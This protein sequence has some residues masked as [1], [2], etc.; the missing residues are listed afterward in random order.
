MLQIVK[1]ITLRAFF[2]IKGTL[3][4]DSSLCTRQ[5]IFQN[6]ISLGS[7]VHT[8]GKHSKLLYFN[9][10]QLCDQINMEAQTINVNN[11]QIH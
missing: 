8:P 10:K 7:Y 4:C 9:H 6:R 11:V 5:L 3:M 2:C 1:Y